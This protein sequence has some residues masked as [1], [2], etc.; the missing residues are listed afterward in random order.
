M[1]NILDSNQTKDERGI[2]IVF[3]GI[4]GAGKTTQVSMLEKLLLDSGERVIRSKEPTD[5]ESGRK[6]KASAYKK[7]L[8]ADQELALFLLDRQEHIDKTIRPALEQG[9]MVILD[10]YYYSTVC[11]QGIGM[12]DIG[13]LYRTVT[14][15]VI[16]PDI[17]FI[18]DVD[19]EISRIRIRERGQGINK[20]E[21]KEQLTKVRE[22]Y[23][24]LPGIEKGTIH[25]LDA[26]RSIDAIHTTVVETLNDT[27]FAKKLCAKKP[28]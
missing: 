5:G 22:N 3:D 2:L 11:Y 6:I 14:K 16:P 21:D 26:S 28:I 8:Q 27:V 25:E 4:D 9:H 24:L 13:E 10:R 17:S 18:L 12:D 20:F 1:E 7:R 15:S 23:K 19:P